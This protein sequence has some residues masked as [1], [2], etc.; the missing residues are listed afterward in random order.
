MPLD[1]DFHLLV[2]MIKEEWRLHR[3]ISGS[4]GSTFFPLLIFAMTTLCA[5]AGHLVF[6]GLSQMTLILILHVASAGY[7]FFVGGFGALAESIMSRRLGQVNML[8]QL[9]QTFPV[10][11]RKMMGIFYVK[12]SLFYLVYTFAPMIFGV[13]VVGAFF[14]Y[15]ALGV[16]WVGVTTFLTFMLGMGI[17]FVISAFLA[18]SKLFGLVTYL[19]LFILIALVWPIG[20]LPPHH[21]LLPFGYWVDKSLV[22]LLASSVIAVVLAAA[23]VLLMR[24]QFETR[25]RRYNGSFLRVDDLFSVFGY[26]R[27]LVAKEWLELTRSGSLAPI[28][29]MYALHL[30]AVYF[31]SWVFENG[32]GISLGFNVVFFSALVGFMGVLAYSSLTSVEP[33]EYLNV[34]P[35]SVD[36]LIKA[37]LLIYFLITSA[38]TFSYVVLIGYLKGEMILVPQSL[39][40]AACNCVFVVAVTAYLT[41]LWTNTMFFGAKTI[42]SFTLLIMP[43]LTVIE[44]GALLLPYIPEFATLLIAAASLIE[45][46]ASVFLLRRL[47]RRWG[48]ATFS[49]ISKSN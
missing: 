18:R 41:G 35:V 39:L 48:N 16:F 3:S 17:S 6:N 31:I 5:L 40:V 11:F 44:M 13:G 33:N 24:E 9:P 38:V 7:G 22:W 45:L 4:L 19:A 8:L 29:G 36:A 1:L 20:I 12:D 42:V 25:S 23:G 49:F 2:D 10:T 47:G 37:K 14:E 46:L 21:I 32:V 27:T 28:I 30:I 43:I 15:S 34:M 26:H